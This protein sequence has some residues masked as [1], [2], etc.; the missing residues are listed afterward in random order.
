MSL[1]RTLGRPF[2]VRVPSP[3][4]YREWWSA[5]AV[6]PFAVAP[7]SYC[8]SVAPLSV[9]RIST[10]HPN[11]VIPRIANPHRFRPRVTAVPIPSFVCNHRTF[12]TQT[13]GLAANQNSR[14]SPTHTQAPPPP[15]TPESVAGE[16][17]VLGLDDASPPPPPPPPPPKSAP[18]RRP[19][20]TATA[21]A[22]HRPS[23]SHPPTLAPPPG[24]SGGTGMSP[25]A[26]IA[27]AVK[28]ASVPHPVA[29]I[30]TAF[31]ATEPGHLYRTE[32]FGFGDN[33]F[34]VNGLHFRGSILA[35][36]NFTVRQYQ[37]PSSAVASLDRV[38]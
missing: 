32:I 22:S 26:A 4:S 13:S 34:N 38:M 12:V 3:E 33:S 5:L 9:R 16:A 30:D 14:Q 37:P 31:P 35:F 28:A 2:G 21:P 24:L 8:L 15:L 1:M 11:R 6:S 29:S 10:A 27:A 18:P 7:L 17:S 19:F 23:T 36:P 20:P 25:T